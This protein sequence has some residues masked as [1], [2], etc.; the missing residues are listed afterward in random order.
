[1]A[2]SNQMRR[3]AGLFSSMVDLYGAFNTRKLA[4]YND[5]LAQQDAKVVEEQAA[6]NNFILDEKAK[7]EIAQLE[8]AG[9]RKMGTDTVSYAKSG[10]DLSSESV[11]MNLA[12]TE[13]Q[14]HKDVE[15]MRYDTSLKKK[16]GSYNASVRAA[17]IRN[18]SQG[19]LYSAK[20]SSINQV[21]G[22]VSN[23]MNT[24]VS[25]KDSLKTKKKPSKYNATDIK[26]ALAQEGGK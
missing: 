21:L 15:L 3:F 22:G 18:K 14:I 9:Q 12:R 2:D 19:N 6:Y 4:K 7:V 24:E 26:E 8:E 10:V 17:S 25:Y 11:L 23:L 20:V 16:A 1:M 13:A 5:D